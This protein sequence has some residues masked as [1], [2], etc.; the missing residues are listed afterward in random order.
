MFLRNAWGSRALVSP[1]FGKLASTRLGGASGMYWSHSTRGMLTIGCSTSL[2]ARPRGSSPGLWCMPR[3]AGPAILTSQR[4]SWTPA[5]PSGCRSKGCVAI[6]ML[7][8]GIA[9]LNVHCIRT[10]HKRFFPSK[11]AC[12]SK[13]AGCGSAPC[14][15]SAGCGPIGLCSSTTC[16]LATSL[17]KNIASEPLLRAMPPV[18]MFIAATCGAPAH[19]WPSGAS[20]GCRSSAGA[21]SAAA[22][23]STSLAVDFTV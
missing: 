18:A 21:G 3:I 15:G 6:R 23:S 9:F 1:S 4:C 22:F 13:A 7:W 20:S 17:S 2:S 8:G 14:R 12:E 16:T 5:C 11:Y 19:G 10:S